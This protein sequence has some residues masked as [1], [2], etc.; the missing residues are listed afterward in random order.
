MTEPSTLCS[1]LQFAS[2][3]E[4]PSNDFEFRPFQSYIQS[5]LFPPLVGEKDLLGE[6]FYTKEDVFYIMINASNI[7]NVYKVQGV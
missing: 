5:P 4:V 7:S 6:A 1:I 3:S 2:D